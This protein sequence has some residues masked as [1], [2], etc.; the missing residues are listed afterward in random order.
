MSWNGIALQAESG[1]RPKETPEGLIVTRAVQ[2]K[3]GWVGQVIVDKQI[4]HETEAWG[5]DPDDDSDNRTDAIREV[6]TYVVDAVKRML[7]T[8]PEKTQDRLRHMQ[9][10]EYEYTAA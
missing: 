8:P 1:E 9:W 10:T 2:T 5:N 6:N 7:S 4:V 3:A